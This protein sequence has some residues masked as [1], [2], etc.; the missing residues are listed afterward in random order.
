MNIKH[1]LISFVLF[2]LVGTLKTNA[3][4]NN[5]Y[6]ADAD[7]AYKAGFYFQAMELYDKAL[8]KVK[9]DKD[10]KAC[11]IFQSAQ[12]FRKMKDYKKAVG[13]Y[14]Q[15]IKAGYDDPKV[16]WYLAM[17]LKEQGSYEEAKIQFDEYAKKNP[18]DPLGKIASESCVNA[19][20]WRNNPTCYGVENLK[21]LNTRNNDFS[22]I[23]SSKK[24]DELIFTSSREGAAGKPDAIVGEIP[25]DLFEAKVDKK[26]KWSAPKPIEGSINTKSSEG[27]STINKK[28]NT[29]Y[30]TRCGLDKKSKV[31]CQI[32]EVKKQGQKW[33]EPVKLTLAAD[34][35]VTGHPTISADGNYMIFSSNMSGGKGGMDLWI[36]KFDKKQ[37]TFANPKNLENINTASNE[38]Y[39]YL[40]TDN[41]LYFSSDRVEGMGGLDIYKADEESEGV[42]KNVVN[43]R[44]PMNS[45]GDDF[46]IVFEGATEKGMLTSNR[47]GGRGKD[48]I[49]TFAITKSSVNLIVT[50]KD[51]DTKQPIAGAKV[52]ITNSSGEKKEFT[53]DAAGKINLN[54]AQ[55]NED[56]ELYATQAK[57]YSG[58]GAANTKG[59][60]PLTTCKDTTVT[61][62]ILIK[63]AVVPLAYDVLFE[64]D[65]H[66]Y[67]P[68]FVDT[69]N[70][71]VKILKDN[72]TM[73]VNIGAH[74]DSRGKDDYNQRLSEGRAKKV[75]AYVVSQGVDQARIKT[76]GYGE[77]EPRVLEYDIDGFKKGT[78]LDD[79]FIN[80]LKTEDERER[81]HKL[82]RRVSL[83]KIDDSYKPKDVPKKEEKEE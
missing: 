22:P 57:Y 58:K 54:P 34:S 56:Y 37:K 61:A 9:K 48:D 41:K 13:K 45:P 64:F 20:K 49:Y 35:F 51:V 39:P 79:A 3:Q 18:S 6:S 77:T 60:D 76:T 7:K 38:M 23:Y 8:S 78:K 17:I 69:L 42:F 80:S 71:I 47:A 83:R 46:G 12:C 68:E 19:V 65:R 81:A 28:F 31:G 24:S 44:Y 75:V 16:Y 52:E 14:Q 33:A 29:L 66:D 15:A 50:V 5:K 25:E 62:E 72:P 55:Y 59:I 82:N 70:K 30:F 53:T 21:A 27:A 11:M 43:M 73:T 63:S 10:A 67:Y 36:A 74:T 1:L 32:Y 2:A 40:R 26:G 4:C